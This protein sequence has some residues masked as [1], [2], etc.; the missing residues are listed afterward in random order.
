MRHSHLIEKTDVPL[1]VQPGIA[2]HEKFYPAQARRLQ[3]SDR[4]LLRQL[5]DEDD[6]GADLTSTKAMPLTPLQASQRLPS[7]V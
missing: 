6:F 3:S 4:D 5:L 7:G 1:R 2:T